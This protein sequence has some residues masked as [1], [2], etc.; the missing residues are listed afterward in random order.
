MQRSINT[1]EITAGL[2]SLRNA[3]PKK[4]TFFIF[5][6]SGCQTKED[7]I[8]RECSMQGKP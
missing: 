6:H 7:G 3:A 1:E 4:L 8:D 2:D 5:H